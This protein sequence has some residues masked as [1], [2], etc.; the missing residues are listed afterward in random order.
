MLKCC[1]RLAWPLCLK[2]TSKIGKISKNG[3]FCYIW[4]SSYFSMMKDWK[5]VFCGWSALFPT[6]RTRYDFTETVLYQI[7]SF[8][9][10]IVRKK[11]LSDH[12]DCDALYD[13][14]YDLTIVNQTL[15]LSRIFCCAFSVATLA[16]EYELNARD[17]REH[18]PQKIC[19]SLRY[20]A[21][22]G[23]FY[24]V[25]KSDKRGEKRYIARPQQRVESHNA[26]YYLPPGSPKIWR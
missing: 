18:V 22:A 21:V 3:H 13:S 1:K 15:E 23:I 10:I 19:A 16:R 8:V 17:A 7:V 14:A 26:A 24:F 2:F 25:N 4:K 11:K 9:I 20:T 6:P 5:I 12:N